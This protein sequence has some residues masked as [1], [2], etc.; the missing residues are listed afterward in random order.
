MGVRLDYLLSQGLPWDEE[1]VLAEGQTA[2]TLHH[3]IASVAGRRLR[4]YLNGVLQIRGLDY[5]ETTSN[6]IDFLC[7][8]H[9]GDLVILWYE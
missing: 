2:L 3:A 4:V 9:G 1:H 7:E 8:V 5:N 6:R